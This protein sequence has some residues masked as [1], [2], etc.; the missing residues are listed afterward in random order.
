MIKFPIFLYVMRARMRNRLVWSFPLS[1]PLIPLSVPIYLNMFILMC[2]FLLLCL[3][4][5]VIDISFHEKCL[6]FWIN[7]MRFYHMPACEAT[8]RRPTYWHVLA[9]P[10]E[11]EPSGWFRDSCFHCLQVLIV[12][13]LFGC[14]LHLSSASCY[15]L[16]CPPASP[17]L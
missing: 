15:G 8:F 13:I 7:I 4:M 6:F 9:V 14:F 11:V 10:S 3:L 1:K 12:F 5:V 17:H 2:G 16:R